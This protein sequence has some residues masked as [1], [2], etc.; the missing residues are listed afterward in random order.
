MKM[1]ILVLLFFILTSLSYGQVIDT[2]FIKKVRKYDALQLKTY[3]NEYISIDVN[4]TDDK[5][6]Y[7]IMYAID[8]DNVGVL[9]VLIS[10]GANVNVRDENGKTPF[11]YA[12]ENKKQAVAIYLID[13]NV[14]P[15]VVDFEGKDAYMYMIDKNLFFLLDYFIA[16]ITNPNFKSYYNGDT[17]LIYAAK[18]KN[19]EL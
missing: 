14:N 10:H 13:Q 9:E 5:G 8:R 16:G 3:L 18:T 2:E 19:D 15:N 4:S 11:I 17:A 12:I 1:K 7:A 6:K